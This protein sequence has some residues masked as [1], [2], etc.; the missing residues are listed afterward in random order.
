MAPTWTNP[1]I[2]SRT[3]LW[4]FMNPEINP[5]LDYN[6]LVNTTG[7]EAITAYDMLMSVMCAMYLL[8]LEAWLPFNSTLSPKFSENIHDTMVKKYLTCTGLKSLCPT[9]PA[10]K[11]FLKHA[12][13]Q[14]WIVRSRSTQGLRSPCRSS[15]WVVKLW[16]SQKSVFPIL[17]LLSMRE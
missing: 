13:I 5:F 11:I 3:G 9:G 1:I 16:C 15:V 10:P 2:S 7:N 4:Y 6:R 12:Q 17:W 14:N 8:S